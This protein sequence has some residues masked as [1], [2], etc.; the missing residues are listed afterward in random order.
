MM[1]PSRMLQLSMRLDSTF[2]DDAQRADAPALS[3]GARAAQHPWRQTTKY[4]RRLAAP[5]RD[6]RADMRQAG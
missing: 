6:Q 2:D 5:T 4:G 1:P 3:S